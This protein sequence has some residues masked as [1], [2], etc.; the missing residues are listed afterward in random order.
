MPGLIL[1]LCLYAGAA[2][3]GDSGGDN[4]SNSKISPVGKS[5]SLLCTLLK[6][7]HVFWLYYITLVEGEDFSLFNSFGSQCE[8]VSGLNLQF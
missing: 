4:D 2:C 1:F 3:N 8:M 5:E 7:Q 6:T